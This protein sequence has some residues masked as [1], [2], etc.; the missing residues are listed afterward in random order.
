MR[1]ALHIRLLWVVMAFVASPGSAAPAVTPEP[2]T[3]DT[4]SVSAAGEPDLALRAFLLALYSNDATGYQKQII[5]SP[6]SE[7]LLGTQ[8]F[9]AQ[10]LDA[11]RNE[12]AAL[13]LRR[14]LTP[15]FEGTPV[16]PPY[17]VGTR[18]TYFASFRGTMLGFPLEVTEDGWKTDVRF[19]LAM[20]RRARGPSE[21]TEP[22]RVAKSF[23]F[24]VLSRQPEHLN[25]YA[26]EAIDG[27]TYTAANDLPDGDLDQVLSLCAEM[28]VVEARLGERVKLPS[29]E[30]AT[31]ASDANSK[32]LI[33]M[34][35]PLPIPFL[36]KRVGP[37]WRVVPQHYF[38]YL[39]RSGS[40]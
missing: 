22:E 32:L 31:G 21:P 8:T 2:H 26:S 11:L 3:V 16:S 19:W 12:I 33:G 27:V 35:G 39:R 37:G 7:L 4:V 30:I 15:S 10:Q 20:A 36:L 25:E 13:P 29:G 40:I 14:V 18:A 24:Y 1:V 5:P 9:T 28:P 17:R 38:E 34:M 23:L 6:G